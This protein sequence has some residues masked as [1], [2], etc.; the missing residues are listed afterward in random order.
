MRDIG[1]AS[2]DRW[3]PKLDW[4]ELPSH[5][6]FDGK[7]VFVGDSG[8]VINT[9]TRSVIAT[10]P[11]MTNSR[12]EIEIDFQNGNVVAAMTNRSSIGAAPALGERHRRVR[13]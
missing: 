12:K 13:P 11:A 9:A 7:Y 5:H 8:D 1:G 10:L 3:N 2:G 6:S 4:I